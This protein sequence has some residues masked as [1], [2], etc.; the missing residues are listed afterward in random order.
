MNLWLR[1]RFSPSEWWENLTQWDLYGPTLA[2]GLSD[3][4]WTVV[5]RAYAELHGYELGLMDIA[6]EEP[7]VRRIRSSLD[8]QTSGGREGRQRVLA[9]IKMAEDA[10]VRLT[11]VA[12]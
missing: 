2:G 7:E 1:I 8:P 3:V 11:R 6:R 12:S 5:D 10:I 4:D 9:T